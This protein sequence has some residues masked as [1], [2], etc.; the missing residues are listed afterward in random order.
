MESFPLI[1]TL[2][3]NNFLDLYLSEFMV[4]PL[5]ILY[6]TFMVCIEHNVVTACYR[7]RFNSEYCVKYARIRVFSHR[8]FPYNDR[9]VYVS[10][11]TRILAYFMQCELQY[12]ICEFFK[13]DSSIFQLA[14]HCHSIN[15]SYE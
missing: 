2:P 4:T 8:I 5:S 15:N 10:E 14:C 7:R 3:P 11:K 12:L 1:Y 6:R 13:G 9:I